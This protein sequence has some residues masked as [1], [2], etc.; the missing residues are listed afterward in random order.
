MQVVGTK[1]LH[2]V[3]RLEIVALAVFQALISTDLGNRTNH[4]GPQLPGAFRNLVRDRKQLAGLFVKKQV[5]VVKV[6]PAHVPVKVL[7][8]DLERENIGQQ[9]AQVPRDCRRRLAWQIVR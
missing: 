3:V 4:G 6:R 7:R 9:Q 5:I 8:L 2:H 1:I